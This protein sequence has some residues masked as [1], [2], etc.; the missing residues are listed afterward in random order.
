MTLEQ[1][2]QAPRNGCLVP[3]ESTALAQSDPRARV[4][5]PVGRQAAAALESV[6]L[7]T[8]CEMVVQGM[9]HR[10]L[11]AVVGVS[12][13]A[14][15]CWFANLRGDAAALYAESLR[16][17]AHALLDEAEAVVRQ[18]GPSSADVQRA[19]CV[20]EILI[21]KAS[22]RNRAFD[23]RQASTV[24]LVD[25]GNAGPAAVPRFVLVVAPSGRT[26]GD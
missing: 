8:L 12:A 19:R 21:R 6:G 9:T 17:S 7:S 5:L 10:E 11:S 25:S 15:S 18:S 2:N 13:S 26:W 23:L 20:S 3:H 1:T 4:M 16:Q 22:L 14:V 24:T